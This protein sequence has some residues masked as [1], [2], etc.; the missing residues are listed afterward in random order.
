[1]SSTGGTSEEAL[2]EFEHELRLD[3]TNANAAYEAAELHRKSGRLVTAL[4]LFS[5]AIRYYPDFEE[6]RV[7][8]GRT[9]VSLGRP[10]EALPELN[11]AVA[12]NRQDEVA[13]Y[14]LSV[15]Y[16][17]LGN[18]TEQRRALAEFQQLRERRAQVEGGANLSRREVTQQKL[19][20]MPPH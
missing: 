17:S 13:W 12:L 6:A 7:G 2:K 20:P 9:L 10:Q 19:D 18:P 1:Q 5:L 14:Q 16:R 8:L 3:A 11:K 4:E 15:A